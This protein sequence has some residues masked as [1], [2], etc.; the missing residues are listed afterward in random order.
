MLLVINVQYKGDMVIWGLVVKHLLHL[1]LRKYRKIGLNTGTDFG[2]EQCSVHCIGAW[3]LHLL[4]DIYGIQY[5]EYC[6]SHPSGI[7]CNKLLLWG[8][9]TRGWS[10]GSPVNGT[11]QARPQYP[12]TSAKPQWVPTS[13]RPHLQPPFSPSYRDG[14]HCFI[15]FCQQPNSLKSFCQLFNH[16]YHSL[17][18][19]LHHSSVSVVSFHIIFVVSLFSFPLGIHYWHSSISGSF[20]NQTTISLLLII[21]S[22]SQN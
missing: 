8:L 2:V 5:I 3:S 19:F 22:L 20:T 14:H 7:G 18:S 15:F 10:E 4:W 12:G 1:W 9:C 11:G 16:S 17:S 21:S 6:T 13:L